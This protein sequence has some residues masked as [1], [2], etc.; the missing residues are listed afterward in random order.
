MARNLTTA[1]TR[2]RART[3]SCSFAGRPRRVMPGVMRLYSRMN[4]ITKAKVTSVILVILT[5]LGPAQGAQDYSE[6]LDRTLARVKNH[7]AETRPGWKHRAIKPIEGSANVSVNNWES[8]GRVVRVAILAYGSAEKAA[9]AMR[10]FASHKQTL[11]GLPRLGDGGY[12]W[13]PGA[14]NVCFRRGDLT[15][16][17]TTGV[18]DLKEAAELSHDFAEQVAAAVTAA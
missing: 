18:I 10:R 4:M 5:C 16:W 7:L 14:S 15:I 1:C 2:P 11:S 9:V 12:S 3:L 6:R 8:G 17:V 13:G